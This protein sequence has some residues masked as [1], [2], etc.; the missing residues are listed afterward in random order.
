MGKTYCKKHK[1]RFKRFLDGCPICA[2]ETMT[3][4]ERPKREIARF[5]RRIGMS[6]KITEQ[7][8][9]DEQKPKRKLKRRKRRE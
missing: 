5:L 8:L 4:P 6:H 2:G 9:T 3:V 1:Q 7:H